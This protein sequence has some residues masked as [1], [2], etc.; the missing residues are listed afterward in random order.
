MPEAPATSTPIPGPQCFNI[1]SHIAKRQLVGE[2]VAFVH[3]R[4][5]ARRSSSEKEEQAAQLPSSNNRVQNYDVFVLCEG[6]A[7]S[8]VCIR[9]LRP[10]A[11]AAAGYYHLPASSPPS[12]SKIMAFSA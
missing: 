6:L 10:E 11:A 12:S 4:A 3:L 7:V 1:V 5:P 2:D 8:E 9:L